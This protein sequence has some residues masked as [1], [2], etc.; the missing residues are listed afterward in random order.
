MEY[1][2]GGRCVSAL[3]GLVSFCLQGSS[4]GTYSTRWLNE[5][6]YSA[7]GESAKGWLDE[8]KA[9]RTKLP[10]PPSTHSKGNRSGRTCMWACGIGF[11]RGTDAVKG[12]RITFRK[13]NQWEGMKFSQE[14]FHDS[15]GAGGKVLM[16]TKL[17]IATFRAR[18]TPFSAPS[19]SKESSAAASLKGKR[20]SKAEPITTSDSETGSESE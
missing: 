20:K 12:G 6:Y 13:S 17:I 1:R 19:S 7:H 15:N 11:V 3:G 9:R 18:S 16:H 4:I 2:V 14:H 8:P 10:W 5:L